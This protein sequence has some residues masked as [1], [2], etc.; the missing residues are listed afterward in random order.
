MPDDPA[1]V[2]R[3]WF[4]LAEYP[5]FIRLIFR[6]RLIQAQHVRGTGGLKRNNMG[7]Q[8]RRLPDGTPLGVSVRQ[9]FVHL[10]SVIS[11]TT[12]PNKRND[13]SLKKLKPLGMSG[14][15]SFM[16]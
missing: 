14:Y 13:H 9:S 6:Y 16:R 5:V 1:A 8:H 15:S 4:A 10:L 11:C 7:V 12:T 2:S 3:E